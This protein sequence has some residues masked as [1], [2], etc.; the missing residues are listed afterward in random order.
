MCE[1]AD[2]G[3]KMPGR[4]LASDLVRPVLFE[5]PDRL[6]LGESLAPGPQMSEKQVDAFLG[7]DPVALRGV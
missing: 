6:P 5:A 4:L 1:L 2:E 7:I 3:A